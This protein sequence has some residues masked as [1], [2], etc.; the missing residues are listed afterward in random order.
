MTEEPIKTDLKN[1]EAYT[2]TE[3]EETTSCINFLINMEFADDPLT[4][5]F[6]DAVEAELER[7]KGEQ[8]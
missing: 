6:Q 1:P 7:R 2:T 4:P 8:S 3:L 5:K